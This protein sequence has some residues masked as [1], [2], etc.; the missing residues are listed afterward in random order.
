[1][2]EEPA[3]VAA[4][5]AAPLNQLS[6]PIK[7]KNGVYV[8]QVVANKKTQET[9]NLQ[10]EEAGLNSMNMYRLM[11]QSFDAVKNTTHIKDSRIKFY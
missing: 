10:Q 6:A 5:T 8:F 1:L 7:G 2:G 11:Y 4:V 3:L 9:F